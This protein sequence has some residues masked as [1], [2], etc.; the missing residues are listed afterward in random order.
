MNEFTL[1]EK[2]KGRLP[3]VSDKVILGIGDD[4]AILKT[5][6]QSLWTI[7]CQVEGVHFDLR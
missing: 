2:L 3:K 6:S 1:I 7:D 4:T 5:P